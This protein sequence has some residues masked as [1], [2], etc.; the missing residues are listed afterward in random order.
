MIETRKNTK[1]AAERYNTQKHNTL[2]QMQEPK[3]TSNGLYVWE[4]WTYK[5]DGTITDIRH[6]AEEIEG[7]K[8]MRISA[9]DYFYFL[10]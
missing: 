1:N 3:R 8:T 7:G 6:Y 5:D 4:V 10:K 9:E 2:A